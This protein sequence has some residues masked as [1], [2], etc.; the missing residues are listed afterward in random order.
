MT[1]DE[2]PAQEQLLGLSHEPS[3]PENLQFVFLG[4]IWPPPD[5]LQSH[6]DR[7]AQGDPQLLDGALQSIGAVLKPEWT[8]PDLRARLRAERAIVSGQDAFLARYA[9]NGTKVQVVVTKYHVH[10]TIA[11]PGGVQPLAAMHVFLRVDF[12]DDRSPWTGGPWTTTQIAGFTFAYQQRA[13]V[14][15]WRDSLNCLTNGQAVKFSVQKL[16][17]LPAASGPP[18]FGIAPTFD[19][20]R[21]WF[22]QP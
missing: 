2:I 21:N 5:A 17:S 6:L 14:A 19:S 3:V 4:L 18:K 9:L 8:A 10:I 12:P 22:K 15:S 16:P 20:E 11:A 13:S 1:V 7:A